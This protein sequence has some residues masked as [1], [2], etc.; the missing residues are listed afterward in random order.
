M[1]KIKKRK[2]DDSAIGS[3]TSSSIEDIEKQ[4]KDIEDG[5]E[6][7]TLHDSSSSNQSSLGIVGPSVSCPNIMIHSTESGTAID[8]EVTALKQVYNLRPR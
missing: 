1:I 4:E 5:F 6:S 8:A 7:I 3:E 2:S